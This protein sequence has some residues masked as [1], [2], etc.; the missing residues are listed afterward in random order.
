MCVCVCVCLLVRLNWVKVCLLTMSN[1]WNREKSTVSRTADS[2]E[3]DSSWN[4]PEV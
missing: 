2:R 1:T 3:T 4:T